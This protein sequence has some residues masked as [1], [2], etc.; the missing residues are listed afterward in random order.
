M[1]TIFKKT[2][3]DAE[4]RKLD[5][6]EV[7]SWVSVVDPTKKEIKYLTKTLDLDE[8]NVLD[9]LDEYE[10]PRI[11]KNKDAAYM[12][13][14]VPVEN[15]G[16]ISTIPI[17]IFMTDRH[18]LTIT[19][20]D[21]K[22]LQSIMENNAKLYTT[23][24]INLLIHIFLLASDVYENY[25]KQISKEIY[26][27]KAKITDLSNRDIVNLIKYEE[28]LNQ[29][30]S[31]FLPMANIFEK[32]LDGKY[33]PLYRQDKEL[34]EDLLVNSRQTLDLCRTNMKTVVNIREAYSTVL[35]N[36][37]NKII[38]FLTVFTILLAVPTTI[39]SLYGMN[40]VLPMQ[41]DPLIFIYIF[42]TIFAVTVLLVLFFMKKKWL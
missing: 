9:A 26:L 13:I 10:V 11:E 36:N 4:L 35:S 42:S 37:L 30:I 23:Q 39:S 28:L 17:A 18:I 31:S 40:V 7:G 38:R 14:K 19:K 41:N 3:K 16:I 29:F 33:L 21:N 27:R 5:S 1:L 8:K 34:I 6:L 12:L 22:V 20:Q 2:I 32:I 25:L 24:K 15:E